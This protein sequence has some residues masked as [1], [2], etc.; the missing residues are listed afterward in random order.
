MLCTQLLHLQTVY[1][2]RS[3]MDLHRNQVTSGFCPFFVKIPALEKS[4]SSLIFLYRAEG[5]GLHLKRWH[6]EL[7]HISSKF[8]Q[9]VGIVCLSRRYIARSL[10]NIFL[11]VLQRLPLRNCDEIGGRSSG[12]LLPCGMAWKGYAT[13]NQKLKGLPNF[14]R[15]ITQAAGWSR[16]VSRAGWATE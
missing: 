14:P 12:N 3:F 11:E 4:L 16:I 7:G 9:G 2:L 13:K 6:C 15:G 1:P 5:L 8:P 10:K